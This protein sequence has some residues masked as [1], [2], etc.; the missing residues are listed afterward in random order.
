MIENRLDAVNEA[1]T[2][3]VTIHARR[4]FSIEQTDEDASATGE[5]NTEGL[6]VSHLFARVGVPY[7][8]I[9]VTR[10]N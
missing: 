8:M 6:N 5:A 2:L 10:K 7:G 4:I 3:I 9:N 1:P